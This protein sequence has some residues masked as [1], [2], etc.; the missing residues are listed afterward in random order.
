MSETATPGADQTNPVVV[1]DN[2]KYDVIA[3]PDDATPLVQLV[4]TAVLQTLEIDKLVNH[5]NRTDDLLYI[6]ACGVAGLMHPTT[7]QALS[8]Q[9]MNLQY[10]LR[11][12]TGEIETALLSFGES[13]RNMLSILRGAFKDLYSLHEAD[14]VT[15]LARCESVATKMAESAGGLEGTFQSLVEQAGAVLQLTSE[16]CNRH[17]QDRLPM[18]Q[19]QLDINARDQGIKAKRAELELQMMTVKTLYE[20][21]KAAQTAADE[22]AFTQAIVSHI[23]VAFGGGILDGLALKTASLKAGSELAAALIEMRTIYPAQKEEAETPTEDAPPL[24]EEAKKEKNAEA[25]RKA[26]EEVTASTARGA[27]AESVGAGLADEGS[28]TEEMASA[29]SAIAATYAKE[30]SRYLDMLIDLQEQECEALDAMAQ[31]ALELGAAKDNEDLGQ[32]AVVSLHHAVATLKQIVVILAKH[33]QIFTQIA[34]NCAR[35][36]QADLRTDIERYMWRPREE[37]IAAYTERVFLVHMLT[38]A[39]QWHALQLVAKEYRSAIQSAYKSMGET[40]TRNPTIE[41]GCQLAAVLGAA[42]AQEVAAE[43][44]LL[45][46]RAGQMAV[47][48]HEQATAIE[49][50]VTGGASGGR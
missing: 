38:T 1:F 30:K 20:K 32:A 37:R 41:E 33:K 34:M 4:R 45:N 17:K 27:A 49:P 18:Q 9:V 21:A 46:E 13:A 2:V 3:G 26:Y 7:Q 36:A 11:T 23:T 10:K 19:R 6:A 16:T 8:A 25:A 35:G 14:A 15:R 28:S 29:C 39:A 22:R 5:L 50:A 43:V 24:T 40:Y 44:R 12:N 48:R 47:K 42:L 31:D